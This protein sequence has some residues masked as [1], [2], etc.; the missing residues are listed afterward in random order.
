MTTQKSPQNQ[1]GEMRIWKQGS[2]LPGL[3]A[4]P[5]WNQTRQE[6]TQGYQRRQTTHRHQDN[7]LIRGAVQLLQ[8]AYQGFCPNCSTTFQ[9]DK[10]GLRL[11]IRTAS[12]ESPESFLH[13]TETA[14]FR[15]GHGLSKIGSPIRTHHGCRNWDSGHSRGPW[16][17]PDPGGQRRQLP[18]YLFRIKAT[19]GP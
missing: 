16:G 17:H 13:S 11:Q 4:H 9:A 10:K 3:H 14:H 18:C 12:R 8:D 15:T 7:T 6:Q 2:L 19:Q 1:P 5:R